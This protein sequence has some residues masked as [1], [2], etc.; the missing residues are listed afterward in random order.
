MCFDEWS[1]IS[2][3]SLHSYIVFDIHRGFNRNLSLFFWLQSLT[4]FYWSKKDLPNTK[5]KVCFNEYIRFRIIWISPIIN[6]I[7][8]PIPPFQIYQY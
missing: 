7:P 1:M 4:Q 3:L 8:F 6:N 5:Q 2:E